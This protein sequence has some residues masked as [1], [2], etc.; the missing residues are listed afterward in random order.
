MALSETVQVSHNKSYPTFKLP[1]GDGQI[2]IGL[3]IRS[4][5]SEL[6]SAF[7]PIVFIGSW[8]MWQCGALKMWQPR[9]KYFSVLSSAVYVSSQDLWT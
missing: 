3:G 1:D 9:R 2:R 4:K 5:I 8:Y 6:R 7:Y